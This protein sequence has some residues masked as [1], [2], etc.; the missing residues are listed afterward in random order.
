[1][2]KVLRSL[3]NDIELSE[4]RDE[5]ASEDSA[6]QM[7]IN[8]T[9][10]GKKKSDE[11]KGESAKTDHVEED[12]IAN[13]S[14]LLIKFDESVVGQA[15]EKGDCAKS[16]TRSEELHVANNKNTLGKTVFYDEIIVDGRKEKVENVHKSES[17]LP[18]LTP[19]ANSIFN[20]F[21]PLNGKKAN[22]N[23]LKELVD[24]GQIPYLY[25]LQSLAYRDFS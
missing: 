22:I 9:I 2:P 13:K 6:P 11:S 19:N 4:I 21:P 20:N 25:T 12:T 16:R 18:P 14:E 8:V 7:P 23:D 3:P 5:S 15:N 1:M 17:M 24:I 10:T